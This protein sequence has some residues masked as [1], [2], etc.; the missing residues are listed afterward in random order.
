MEQGQV[1]NCL[2]TGPRATLVQLKH[3]WVEIF[4]GYLQSTTGLFIVLP[5]V[6]EIENVSVSGDRWSVCVFQIYSFSTSILFPT[7]P[8]R[9]PAFLSLTVLYCRNSFRFLCCSNPPETGVRWYR[10]SGGLNDPTTRKHPQ[11]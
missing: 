7:F 9:F 6:P 2:G 5:L 10:E 11:Q 3:L 1:L 8:P 4:R